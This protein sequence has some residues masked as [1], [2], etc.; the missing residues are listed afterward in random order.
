MWLQKKKE[1]EKKIGKAQLVCF[2]VSSAAAPRFDLVF[3][4]SQ[5]TGEIARPDG[6]AAPVHWLGLSQQSLNGVAG[7]WGWGGGKK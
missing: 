3:Y 6:G 7:G 4:R 1:R 2:S 5:S